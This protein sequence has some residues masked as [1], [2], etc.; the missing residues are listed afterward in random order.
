VIKICFLKSKN[1]DK[2]IFLNGAEYIEKV[3]VEDLIYIEHFTDSNLTKLNYKT[4][5]PEITY[6]YQIYDRNW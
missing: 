4:G 6:G 2:Y 5:A 3:N 1:K